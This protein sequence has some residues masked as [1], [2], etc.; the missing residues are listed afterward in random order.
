MPSGK[1]LW[2]GVL[3]GGRR[4][5]GLLVLAGFAM[6]FWN[7][8]WRCVAWLASLAKTQLVPALLAA[9]VVVAGAILL[10]TLLV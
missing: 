5:A 1:S 9:N 10:V 3:R 6:L 2:R 7:L 8:E 4:L